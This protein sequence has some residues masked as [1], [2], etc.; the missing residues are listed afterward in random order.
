M[1]APKINC[2]TGHVRAA[3][4]AAAHNPV[5]TLAGRV[6][7]ALCKQSDRA[8]A[9]EGREISLNEERKVPDWI[10]L[11]PRGPEIKG[12]DGRIWT[13]S[14]PE[15]V[16]AAFNAKKAD[17]IVDYE[18][19]SELLADAGM[20]APASGWINALELRDDGIWGKVKWTEKAT[21]MIE[22][23]EYRYISPG[24]YYTKTGHEVLGFK[25][26]GLVNQPNL[27]LTALNREQK[28][29]PMDLAKLREALGLDKD[30]DE[31]AIL[32]AINTLK[33]DKETALNKAK[34]PAADEFV[35]MA[36]H[37]LALNK[38]SELQAALAKRDADTHTAA[39]DTAINKALSDGKIAPASEDFY[40]ASCKDADGLT[41]FNKFCE[42]AP[43]V[44]PVGER[45]TKQVDTNTATNKHGLTDAELA[46][47]KATGT[48]PK[49]FAENKAAKEDA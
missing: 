25:S 13:M 43:V 27:P 37:T 28:E 2:P 7:V 30:A 18:H 42:A 33:T 23:G 22:A 4:F 20:P 44:V 12:V 41:A 10:H 8:A 5:S 49:A 19:G 16:I 31:S 9:G 46:V 34:T 40:R 15:K 47:C 39:V 11:L 45:V 29:T 32:T 3:L 38:A 6:A 35:P 48:D 14:S 1:Q 21:N 26:V 17:L 36:T 24:F